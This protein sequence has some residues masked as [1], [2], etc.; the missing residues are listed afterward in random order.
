MTPLECFAFAAKLRTNLPAQKQIDKIDELLYRLGLWNCKDTRIGDAFIKGLSGG[1]RKRCSI[2]YELIT[3]PQF[4]L[5]DEP[6]SGLDSIT[7]LK[8]VQTLKREADRGKTIIC[9]IHS[10]SAE[11]FLEINRLLLLHEGHEIYYGPTDKI[12]DYLV[13]LSI[14]PSRF[15]N[16]A[17]FIINLTQ[18][19]GKI[20]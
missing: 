17:D 12:T 13:S 16:I 2:G 6:T 1:E 20:K 3:E 15:I 10:P 4:I 18:D 9:T 8:L 5:L 11:A 14:Q 19:P 7:A